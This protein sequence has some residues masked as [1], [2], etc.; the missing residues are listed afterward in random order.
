MYVITVGLIS[1]GGLTIEIVAGRM[2]APYIGMSL[3]TWTAII[4]VVLA[5]LSIGH[6]IGGRLA[7]KSL[8]DLEFLIGCVLLLSSISALASLILLRLLSGPIMNLGMPPV[9]T[10]T[11]LTFSLFFLPSFFIGIPSP[12]LTKIGIERKRQNIGQIVGLMYASGS[13]GGILG[14]LAAGYIFISWLGTINT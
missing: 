5:G 13:V 1:A 4:A 3:Y 8:K 14:T 12:I 9:P 11:L 2:L 7:D 10:I 6:W